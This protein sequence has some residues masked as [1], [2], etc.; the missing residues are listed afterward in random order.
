MHRSLRSA[1]A[2]ILSIILV[3]SS[4]AGAPDDP[5]TLI[6]SLEN[7]LAATD[8]AKR[9]A[10]LEKLRDAYSKAARKAQEEG[11]AAEAESYRENLEI[12]NRKPHSKK[13]PELN[14]QQPSAAATPIPAPPIE[15]PLASTSPPPIVSPPSQPTTP[16]PSA[17]DLPP[18]ATPHPV[19]D[20][21]A[22]MRTADTS[23]VAANY[24]QA[25]SLY[26]SLDRSKKLPADRRGHW[27]YCRAADVVMR[28][29][30]RP[31]SAQEW[32]QI[33]SEIQAIRL[34]SPSLWF[35]EYL[36]NLSTERNRTPTPRPGQPKPQVVLRGSSP[37][38]SPATSVT[39]P[40][41]TPSA[42]QPLRWSPQPIETPNFQVIHLAKDR[43]LAVS[44]AQ[45]AEAARAAESKRW[46]SAEPSPPWTPKCE[47][48]LFPTAQV[49]GR[50]TYQPP[51]SPG[52]SSMGMNSGQIV[53]RRV[54]LRADHP[55]LLKAILPHEVTHVVLADHFLQQP[56][57]RWADEGMAVLAEPLAE[58][59][60]R[61]ADLEEPLKSGQL[62]RLAD[63]TAMDS[64]DPKFWNLY[65]AQ[66]VSLT[67]FLA[68]TGSPSQ[69]VRC[70]QKSQT[71]GLD[72]ALRQVYSISGLDDL[73]ARWL[74]YAHQKSASATITA[75]SHDP[76]KNP[77][78][79]RR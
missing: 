69:L 4:R 35:A 61:A 3:A 41:P 43:E 33:N 55:N 64:P 37:E 16:V 18:L 46:G 21:A 65:Y 71:I 26:A 62:F 53:L 1:L 48:V 5:K 36:R 9:A 27:A 14:S 63:L 50:E 77:A 42:D 19:S 59:A 51:E 24:A 45:A 66:S 79:S 2:A 28:I 31:A 25:G 30:A 60:V 38:E 10:L 15:I 76:E 52:F 6:E 11:R 74:A 56:I 29:N 17:P 58:Q 75:S 8:P 54:H 40:P 44:L 22:I 12:L 78:P 34:L 7:T 67:R 20:D 70:L 57:P 13:A 32:T 47:I 68:E 39:P 72:Q 73:Q 49:F 23:F